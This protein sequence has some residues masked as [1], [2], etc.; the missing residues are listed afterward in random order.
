[1]PAA[2]PPDGVLP[3]APVWLRSPHRLHVQTKSVNTER[4]AF[5]AGLEFTGHPC[6]YTALKRECLQQSI[7]S[8]V[9]VFNSKRLAIYETRSAVYPRQ[10][11][12]AFLFSFR[13]TAGR[14]VPE[15]ETFREASVQGALPVLARH[16]FRGHRLHRLRGGFVQVRKG[17]S[18][19]LAVP[20][21][22]LYAGDFWYE[23]YSNIITVARK[24]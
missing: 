9:L 18:Q 17:F 12:F 10:R 14:A 1:M 16:R 5:V 11:I 15:A 3:T 2:G 21:V 7:P 23:Y 8:N 13:S 6:S 19:S 24:L 20:P 4:Q 22:W